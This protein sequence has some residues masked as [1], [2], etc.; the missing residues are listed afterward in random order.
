MQKSYHLQSPIFVTW[1]SSFKQNLYTVV[2]TL[3][4]I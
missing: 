3:F 2:I 1:L 4:K